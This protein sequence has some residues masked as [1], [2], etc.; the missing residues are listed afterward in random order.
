MEEEVRDEMLDL[1]SRYQD[2]CIND[3]EMARMEELILAH[4]DAKLMA[5]TVMD[6]DAELK[7]Q[8]EELSLQTKLPVQKPKEN[9]RIID[10]VIAIAA[11]LILGFFFMNPDTEKV[12]PEGDIVALI[13]DSENAE[14]ARF[15][16]SNRVGKAL[17]SGKMNLL[18]GNI[19]MTFS[20]GAKVRVQGPASLEIL[21]DISMNL[22]YGQLSAHIPEEA[23]GFTINTSDVRVIDLGTE[24]AVN[25]PKDGEPEVHVYSGLVQTESVRTEKIKSVVTK[26][27]VRYSKSSNDFEG[28]EFTTEKFI[29]PP[30]FLGTPATT[31]NVR[32]LHRPPASV[33]HKNFQHN[34]IIAFPEKEVVLPESLK[35]NGVAPG[36]EPHRNQKGQQI[37]AHKKLPAGTKVKSFMLHYDSFTGS[38]MYAYGS[39]TFPHEILGYIAVHRDLLATDSLLGSKETEYVHH[40]IRGLDVGHTKMAQIDHIILS[41][42]RKT[43]V[44]SWHNSI[45]IDQV[46]VLVAVP[47]E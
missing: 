8:Q 27:T 23:K 39:I 15:G 40:N 5:L 20:N 17:R 19:E 34:Y 32:F 2:D 26:E 13:S 43:L 30:K 16:N 36:R 44:L 4:E 18:S 25:L 9:L 31:G 29:H 46:R 22:D 42:D 45:A 6:M 1:L 37:F 3:A 12:M 38:A 24:F 33:K 10:F 47:E 7:M 28:G 35:V 21:N 11:I 14:W 41:E